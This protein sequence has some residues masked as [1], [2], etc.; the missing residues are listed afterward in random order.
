MAE[1]LPGPLDLVGRAFD[2]TLPANVNYT[3][4]TPMPPTESSGVPTITPAATPTDTSSIP[5]LTPV[6]S[7]DRPSEEIEKFDPNKIPPPP[8]ATTETALPLQEV[9]KTTTT[10]EGLNLKPVEA[11][12]ATADTFRT[13]ALQEEQNAEEIRQQVKSYGIQEQEQALAEQVRLEKESADRVQG[14]QKEIENQAKLLD[15][16]T[17]EKKSFWEAS[18]TGQKVG[19]LFNTLSALAY[20]FSRN[21]D[22]AIEQSDKTIQQM[23]S[24]IDQDIKMQERKRE[25]MKESLLNK[26][27]DYNR[28]AGWEAQQIALGAAKTQRNLGMIEKKFENIA[29]NASMPAQARAKAAEAAAATQEKK[30]ALLL[31]AAQAAAKTVSAVTKDVPKPVVDRKALSTEMKDAAETAKKYSDKGTPV[32][33]YQLMSRAEKLLNSI[34]NAKTPEERQAASS[35]IASFIATDLQQGS[36]NVELAKNIL[37]STIKEDLQSWVNYFTGKAGEAP[38]GNIESFRN[39]ATAKLRTLEQDPQFQQ[40]YSIYKD[41]Q[42]V[43]ARN[44]ALLSGRNPDLPITPGSGNMSKYKVGNV[45]GK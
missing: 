22:K 28:V 37:G 44:A 12:M 29:N 40:D 15:K 20:A 34:A 11:G 36:F 19:T 42:A 2:A 17:I 30:N 26:T 14:I 9:T 5:T 41:N 18:D 27:N 35:A 8:P 4:N 21:P 25:I 33:E 16:Q 38:R 23:N 1:R 13:Q 39:M 32:Y 24:V 7:Q 10:T 31:T 45:R 43:V 6:Y 3:I